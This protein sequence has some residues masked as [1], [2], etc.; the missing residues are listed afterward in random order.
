MFAVTA[1]MKIYRE[2]AQNT[3]FPLHKMLVL[4]PVRLEAQHKLRR[5]L[6][7]LWQLGDYDEEVGRERLRILFE[8]DIVAV[9][10]THGEGLAMPASFDELLPSLVTAFDR[11]GE[12]PATQDGAWSVIVNSLTKSRPQGDGLTITHFGDNVRKPDDVAKLS[13]VFGFRPGYR[14]LVRLLFCDPDVY[15]AFAAYWQTDEELRS[16]LSTLAVHGPNDREA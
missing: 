16:E 10:R 5:R 11:I 8:T 4:G 14:D 3:Q 6:D 7:A 2:T 12:S 13:T 1:A 9:S 15:A